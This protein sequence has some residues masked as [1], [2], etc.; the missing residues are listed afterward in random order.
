MIELMGV[1]EDDGS[2]RSLGC[3]LAQALRPQE[4]RKS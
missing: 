4:P 1:R 3:N 2:E